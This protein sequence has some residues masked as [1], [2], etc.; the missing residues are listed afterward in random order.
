MDVHP[1]TDFTWALNL[2]GYAYVSSDFRFQQR[3]D[4]KKGTDS[5]LESPFLCEDAQLCGNKDRDSAQDVLLSCNCS[6]LGRFTHPRY[7]PHRLAW[8]LLENQRR[9]RRRFDQRQNLVISWSWLMFHF[10]QFFTWCD[11]LVHRKSSRAATQFGKF[12]Q[13]AKDEEILTYALRKCLEIVDHVNFC[14]YALVHVVYRYLAKFSYDFF[15][16]WSLSIFRGDRGS[17]SYV[18]LTLEL[19]EELFVWRANVV[20]EHLKLV[21]LFVL[22]EKWK[23]SIG[24]LSRP[25]RAHFSV[26]VTH[27]VPRS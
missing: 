27:Y 24:E 3:N 15:Y 2:H 7:F 8:L 4:C 19:S 9:G 25:R 11:F 21:N 18:V 5:W 12:W 10:S 23:W 16:R 20:L 22:A 13:S 1:S 26:R 14:N 6:Q 17:L